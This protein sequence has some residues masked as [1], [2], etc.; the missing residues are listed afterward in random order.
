VINP[1]QPPSSGEDA[2][3]TDGAVSQRIVEALRKT[4]PWVSLVAISGF[5]IAGFSMLLGVLVLV[6]APDAEMAVGIG[7]GFLAWGSVVL[8]V[9]FPLHRYG[10]GIRRLLYGG[11]MSELEL[12]LESQTRFWQLAGV[13][14]LISVILSASGMVLSI[15]AAAALKA[16][17]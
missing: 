10:R 17:F 1:Y 3:G 4:K 12:A 9:S 6:G 7:V 13:L 5:V 2:R 16:V 11:G 15:F 8:G 14:T